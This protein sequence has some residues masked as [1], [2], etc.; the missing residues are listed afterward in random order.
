M[1]APH[2]DINISEHFRANGVDELDT[3]T[4]DR[5]VIASRA[6]GRLG[7]GDFRDRHS[8]QES[9]IFLI[10]LRADIARLPPDKTAPDQA[11]DPFPGKAESRRSTKRHR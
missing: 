7:C 2:D 3:A 4:F 10:T 6:A 1:T 5:D 11:H 8:I 9:V